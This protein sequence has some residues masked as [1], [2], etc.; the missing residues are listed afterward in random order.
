MM[1]NIDQ[2]EQT[3]SLWST[4]SLRHRPLHLAACAAHPASSRSCWAAAKSFLTHAAARREQ[5]MGRDLHLARCWSSE[6]E[7]K[8]Q[9]TI[10]RSLPNIARIRKV[11]RKNLPSRELS[12]IMASSRNASPSHPLYKDSGLP[13]KTVDRQTPAPPTK[14]WETIFGWYLW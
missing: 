8:I 3:Q 5:Q 2:A 9:L 12:F 7:T 11:Q 1:L 14:P 6:G 13:N 10:L 4:R